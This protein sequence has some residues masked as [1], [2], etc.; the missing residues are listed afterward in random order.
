[1]FNF[2]SKDDVGQAIG[3]DI[4]ASSIKVVQLRREK[5]KIVLDTYG[6]IATGPYSGRSVGL[7][8]HLGEEKTVEA[9]QT[10]FKEAK[11]TAREVVV[12]IDPS[13]SYVSLI[14]V[15][16]VSDSEL[17]NMMPFEARKYIPIPISEVQ[18]DWWHVPTDMSSVEG[19]RTINIVLA[20][21]KN[22]TLTSYDRIMKKLELKDIEYEIHGYSLMRSNPPLT[23]GMVMYV[24]IGSLY[25]TLSLVNNGIVLDMQVISRGSQENTLQLSK[26]LSISVDVAEETK[27]TFGYIG[28]SSN[29]YV[30]DVMKLS[31]YPLFGE[32][33]RLSL[34]FERKYNQ[35][36]EG[37][38]LLGGGARL[39]GMLSVY[40]ETV[41]VAGKIASP[42]NQVEIPSF[43]HEMIEKI[44]PTYAVAVGC[45]LKKLTS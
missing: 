7:G 43:L 28:D 1:M 38:I 4:G 37:I 40:E 17:R 33:A 27:R 3:I 36:I 8:T 44:G 5:E 14:K 11:I 15:P 30:K 21:V 20:T 16:K 24:D 42:F 29:Q 10:L 6:E 41:H 12:A 35:T 26:A 32:V 39:P 34:M 13:S 2:L 9:I 22:E 31:S 25:T 23:K 45:A 18:M 19:G